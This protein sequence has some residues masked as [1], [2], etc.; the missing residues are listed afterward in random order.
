MSRAAEKLRRQRSLANVIQVYIRTSPFHIDQAQYSNGMTIPLATPTDDTRQLLKV[1]LWVLKRI[2]RP[3]YNYA[4]AGL[5][6]S[7]LIPKSSAQFDF[8]VSTEE[9]SRSSALMA[10]MDQINLKMG[11]E[12]IKLASEGFNCPWQM[13]QEIRV[14]TIRLVGK[15][16]CMCNAKF[17]FF[18]YWVT[19]NLFRINDTV[20][21]SYR[22]LVFLGIIFA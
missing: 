14:P 13:R 20:T 11:R 2:Y 16:Y 18:V 12:S 22:G 15:T 7:D 17:Y 8:F 5:S 19:K 3:G 21:I 1:A 6:L 10:M 9:S 4:K